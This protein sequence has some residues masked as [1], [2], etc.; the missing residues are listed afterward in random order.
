MPS[1]HIYPLAILL[2]VVYHI[3]VGRRICSDGGGSETLFR[4]AWEY[5]NSWRLL[6]DIGHD[7]MS[8]YNHLSPLIGR[9]TVFQTPSLIIATLILAKKAL[10][11]PLKK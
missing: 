1:V 11:Y 8:N 5:P 7:G 10:N 4:R 2:A 6:F 3:V 9:Y